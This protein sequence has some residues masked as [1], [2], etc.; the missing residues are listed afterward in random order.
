MSGRNKS[1][2]TDHYYNNYASY[3]VAV[4]GFAPDLTLSL[5]L[6][7]PS[8]STHLVQPLATTTMAVLEECERFA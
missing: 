2:N 3:C 6:S 7:M 1:K 5:P 4:G 8:P